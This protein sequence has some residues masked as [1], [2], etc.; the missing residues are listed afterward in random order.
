MSEFGDSMDVWGLRKKQ[1]DS[2]FGSAILGACWS[3]SLGN[4]IGI[5]EQVWGRECTVRLQ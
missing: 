2:G 3:L 4:K 5:E 1:D